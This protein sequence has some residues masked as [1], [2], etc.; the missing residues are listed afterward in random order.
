MLRKG[1]IDELNR[2]RGLEPLVEGV[3]APTGEE[4]APPS[5]LDTSL[6]HQSDDGDVIIVIT[7]PGA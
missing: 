5:S 4:G 3:T 7:P 2:M 6:V 1:E